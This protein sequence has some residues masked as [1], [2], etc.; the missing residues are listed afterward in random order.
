MASTLCTKKILL[1][2][3]N[4]E[5]TQQCQRLSLPT[6]L[7]LSMLLHR[8]GS[9]WLLMLLQLQASLCVR[10]LL[11]LCSLITSTVASMLV[12]GTATRTLLPYSTPS[13][14]S[15]MVSSPAQCTHLTWM[16]TRL[17][18]TLM[19]VYQLILSE[20]A[21]VVPLMALAYLLVSH[22]N[23]VWVLRTS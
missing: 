11:A 13:S 15:I 10:Q 12:T 4:M 5:F 9:S 20:F 6:V 2:K 7:W 17:R 8:C 16:L 23:S 21:L 14:R 19:P 18:A 22:V 3:R 1:F